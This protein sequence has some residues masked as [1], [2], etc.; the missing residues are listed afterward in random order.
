MDRY[1]LGNVIKFIT[2]HCYSNEHL[3]MEEVVTDPTCRLCLE[4][5]EEPAHL[6]FECPTLAETRRILDEKAAQPEMKCLLEWLPK[7]LDLFLSDENISFL[8]CYTQ[9]LKT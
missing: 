3:Y 2:G 8:F 1:K 6:F 4:E 9:C 7:R 5:D